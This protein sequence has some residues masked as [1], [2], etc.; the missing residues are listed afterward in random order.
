LHE[1]GWI[2]GQNIIIERRWSPSADRLPKLAAEL[3]RMKV[4][5]IFAGASPQVEAARQATCSPPM[6]IQWV[7]AMWRAW[8]IFQ[9]LRL[10]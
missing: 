10:R 8:R 6:V 3:V 4:D 1:L 9:D 7:P 2:E 5:V